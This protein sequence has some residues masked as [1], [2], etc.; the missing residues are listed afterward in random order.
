MVGHLSGLHNGLR[1][2]NNTVRLSCIF[3]VQFATS[4]QMDDEPKL[5]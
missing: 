1:K 2:V 4:C 3:K 5:R